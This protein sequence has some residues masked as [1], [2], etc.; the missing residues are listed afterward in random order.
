[1]RHAESGGTAR[2]LDQLAAH[3]AQGGHRVTVVGRTHA[4][5]PHPEVR[6]ARLR[7]PAIGSAWRLWSF[8]RAVERYVAENTFDVVYGLGRTWSQDILRL[9]GGSH[10]TY[11]ELAHADTGTA[12]ER[13]LRLG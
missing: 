6:F 10:R 4:R 12:W 3:L 8:A 5:A 2:Y 7:P 11:L 9:G 1:M 13:R